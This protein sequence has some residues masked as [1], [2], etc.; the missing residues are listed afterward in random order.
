MTAVP[1]TH[2]FAAGEVVTDT[3]M[4][5]SVTAPLNFLLARPICQARQAVAQ[6]IATGGAGTAV[7]FD[8]EDVDSSGMHSTVSNTSRLTAVYP[9]WYEHSGGVSWAASAAGFRVAA[10]QV[11]ST[12]VN[13]S[14]SDQ[15]AVA[16]LSSTRL[17]A[18]TMLLFLNVADFSE[19]NAFQSSGGALNT[20]VTTTEQATAT[21]I[22]TSN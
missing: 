8:S 16:A 22:W 21:A 7:T 3:T 13:G 5:N 17:V 11:N 9:G 19:L 12:L 1:V 10:W 2:T 6:S 14:G 15:T 18:R 4:N 20:A